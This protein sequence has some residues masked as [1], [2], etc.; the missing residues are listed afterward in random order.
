LTLFWPSTRTASPIAALISV[1]LPRWVVLESRQAWNG[2]FEPFGREG[3][4]RE[5]P[6]ALDALLD[7]RLAVG[8]EGCRGTA[9][10]SVRMGQAVCA[11]ARGRLSVT[12]G[13][14][15]AL[16][17]L[18]WFKA[19]DGC[20]YRLDGSVRIDA[21]SPAWSL[22]RLRGTLSTGHRPVGSVELRLDLRRGLL[23]VLRGLRLSA[24]MP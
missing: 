5:T 18:I 22:S 1:G 15:P 7:V 4:G 6:I 20:R 3:L 21:R 12:D 23:E 11:G 16:R 2:A 14:R 8:P 13:P 19:P 24:E 9:L 17:I 10:G